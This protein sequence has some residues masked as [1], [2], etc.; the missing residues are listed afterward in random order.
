[1]SGLFADR[2]YQNGWMFYIV[3][4]GT[5]I[6][7]GNALE[8]VGSR[9]LSGLEYFSDLETAAI[10]GPVVQY[11]VQQRLFLLAMDD[12]DN[13]EKLYQLAG[14]DVRMAISSSFGYSPRNPQIERDSNYEM[15][16]IYRNS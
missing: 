15:D 10:Y 11:Q 3:E 5:S 12:L 8:Y 14:S 1:M 4:S 2:V 16:K 9:N 6:Y 13:L 7:R